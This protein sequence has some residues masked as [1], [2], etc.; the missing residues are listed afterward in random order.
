MQEL[1]DSIIKAPLSLPEGKRIGRSREGRPVVAYRFGQGP[2]R[3]S[4][5]AGCHSDEPV[6]PRL[7]RHL[8]AYLAH[9]PQG[10]PIL[11]DYQWW[12]VPHA[13]PDGEAVNRSWYTEQDEQIDLIAYL[14]HV[15]RELP[16]DDMEFGFPRDPSDRKARPENRSIAA[17]WAKADGPFHLHLSLHGMAFSGGPYFLI[18]PAWKSR[19][20]ELKE[21]CGR[22]VDALGY[23]FH[24]ADRQGEK[25]FFRLGKGFATRP[26]SKAMT[27]HFLDQEDEVTARK[28]R[29]SSMETIR[30]LGGDPLTLVTEMPLFLL[31]KVGEVLGPPDPELERW[32]GRIEK[33]KREL[34]SQESEAERVVEEASRLG[35]TAMPIQDQM[36]LQWV[37]I[38]AGLE[39]LE[40]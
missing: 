33:W 40:Q 9:L 20:E 15:K 10:S 14:R 35:L 21:K 31:P 4:L 5:I 17:W 30:N 22:A 26:N 13:N 1:F 7:A 16:G 2:C 38:V 18:E 3:V 25:G 11:E 8:V 24:D 37:L 32:K 36:K 12:I 27:Q 6:G 39:Q 34:R 19:C 28:F 23:R 29:P